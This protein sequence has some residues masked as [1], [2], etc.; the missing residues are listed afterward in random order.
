MKNIQRF[1]P[2]MRSGG[3]FHS[4]SSFWALVL[5]CDRNMAIRGTFVAT[6]ATCLWPDEY[7]GGF[8]KEKPLDLAPNGGV[9]GGVTL[10]G[11]N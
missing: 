5:A 3:N 9:D 4:E 11:F 1:S 10:T 8:L 2:K 7:S 6:L